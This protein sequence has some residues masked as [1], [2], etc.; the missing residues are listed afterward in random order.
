[1][2]EQSIVFYD[3]NCVVCDVEIGMYKRQERLGQ[4]IFVDI[5]SEEFKKYSSHISF[6]DANREI[7]VM[8]DGKLVKGIDSF[9]VIW[10]NLPQKRYKT[11]SSIVSNKYVRPI[12]DV[13]YNL[14][15]KYRKYF[16]KKSWFKA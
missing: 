10:S 16:P 7:H 8:K 4:L 13:L 1:M 9:L 12:A 5:Q 11:F 6:N 15:A 14:F 2:K 3:G